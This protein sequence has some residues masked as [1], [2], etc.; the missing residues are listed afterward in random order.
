MER[1]R[2]GWAM[3]PEVFR[4]SRC[5]SPRPT[6]SSASCIGA[7]ARSYNKGHESGQSAAG[8][9]LPVEAYDNF[10]RQGVPRW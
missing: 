7:G 2:S 6:R 5:S 9:P 3:T 8:K 10:T 1:G 4:A